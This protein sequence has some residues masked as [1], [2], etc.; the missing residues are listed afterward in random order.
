MWAF[1]R[2]FEHFWVVA[3]DHEICRDICR[4]AAE[5]AL[6]LIRKVANGQ[7]AMTGAVSSPQQRLNLAIHLPLRNQA[8]LTQLLHDL[9]GPKS[10]NL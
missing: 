7:A 1:G 3:I 10:A 8:E 2:T 9:Y 5:K 4:V 6:V